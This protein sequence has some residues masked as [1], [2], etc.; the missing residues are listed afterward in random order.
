MVAPPSTF[1]PITFPTSQTSATTYWGLPW[2][3]IQF[4]QPSLLPEDFEPTDK[5]R[6]SL[7]FEDDL[8]NLLDC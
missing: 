8:N 3:T 4:F 1:T 7:F 5:E 6:P 2:R